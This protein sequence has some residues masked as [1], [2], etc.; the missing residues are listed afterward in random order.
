VQ[1]PSVGTV[2]R[3]ILAKQPM[4][5]SFA[6]IHCHF[7]PAIDDGARNWDESLTMAR[8]AIA[9]GI[10]TIVATPHQLGSF[11]QNRAAE[12]RQLAI[13]FQRRLAAESIPLQVVPGGEIRFE[14]ELTEHL[15]ADEI[16]TLGDHRRHLLLE[17][18]H[19]EYV[20][21]E[22]LLSEL[23][24]RQLTAILA[25]PERNGGFLREPQLILPL[26]E[27]GCLT[28][29]T[30]GSL[31]GIHGSDPKDLA[32]WLVAHGLVHFVATDAHGI[33]TRRPL[34]RR[35]Y[36]RIAE[37]ADDRTAH[38]L[39]SRFPA[40]VAAGQIVT[41]GRRTWLGQRWG[42]WWARRASA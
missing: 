39:C 40:R 3:F 31:C 42:R 25:H 35:A 8:I 23:K 34:M 28:Q 21:L 22:A 19:E 13:E 20:P 4:S 17:L 30:A 24:G 36:E 2:V 11:A 14:S 16:L 12:I 33:R 6:D 5:T 7:L 38:D 32:E 18:P 27:A 9:D 37:L 29:I 10:T 1:L 41:A 26:V 15:D